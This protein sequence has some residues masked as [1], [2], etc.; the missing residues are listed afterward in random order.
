MHLCRSLNIQKANKLSDVL[1]GQGIV[2][3]LGKQADL[4]DG[5]LVSHRAIFP[6]LEF[7]FLV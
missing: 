4:E 7:R 1:L 3:F 2:T 5:G 6:E